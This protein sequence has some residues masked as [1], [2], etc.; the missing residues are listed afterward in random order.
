M[1]LYYLA[2]NWESFWDIL[3]TYPGQRGQKPHHV[4]QAARLHISHLSKRFRVHH[5]N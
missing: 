2:K 5:L 3:G 4:Q 1:L